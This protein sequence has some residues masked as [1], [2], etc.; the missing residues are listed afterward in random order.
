MTK[1]TIYYTTS[2]NGDSSNCVEFYDCQEA[3]DLLEEHDPEGYASGEGGGKFDIDGEI[4]G[5]DIRTLAQ[6]Q[7]Q[8]AEET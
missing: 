4:T 2:D 6:V 8:V 3:I 5:I 7:E 1:K